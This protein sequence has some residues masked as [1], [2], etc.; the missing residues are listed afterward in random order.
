MRPRAWRRRC[1]TADF[2]AYVEQAKA[3]IAAANRP[4]GKELAPQVLEDRAPFELAPDPERCP[5]DRRRAATR[6]RR[7]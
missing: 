6:A 7:C 3:Q 5:R 1:R 2:A 4:I